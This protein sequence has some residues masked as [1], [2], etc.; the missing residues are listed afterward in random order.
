MIMMG[1]KF[2]IKRI[3]FME[4]KLN[5]LFFYYMIKEKIGNIRWI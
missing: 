3:I 2:R 1:P 5:F 4:D